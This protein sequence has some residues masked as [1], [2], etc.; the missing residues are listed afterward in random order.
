[1]EQLKIDNDVINH[2]LF[3]KSLIDE[4][5]DGTRINHYVNM[6]Q[7]TNDGEYISIENP[8]DRSIAIAFELVMKEHL[9]PW[10]IDLVNFST[11]Y[12]KR[13]K[14]EKIDL[15]TAGRIIYMA[16][17]VLKLQSDKL[18]VS[19]KRQEEESEPFGWGD[20]PTEMWLS[21]DD[22]YSY[23]NLVINMPESP[24]DKPIR[25]E[26]N[27]KVTLM[28][29][30]DAFDQARKDSEEYQ[31]LEKQRKEERERLSELARKRMKG[32]A[33]EDHL[34]E[35]V[36]AVWDKINKF[37]KKTISL[38]D[39]CEKKGREELIRVLMSVLFLAYD[40][41]ILVYQKRFPFGKIYVKNTGYS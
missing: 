3:H 21:K 8:F 11:I 41:K 14:E 27:R 1:M 34:E 40:N 6:L 31:I 32:T 29:L 15:M 33:V 9:N 28:E 2:L 5:D 38:V 37:S 4:K 35:D 22:D 13:A 24:L 36:K 7:K 39:L 25:R 20:I 26:A 12:L 17:K 10:D 16:W 23:T 18:V 30:V 19:M